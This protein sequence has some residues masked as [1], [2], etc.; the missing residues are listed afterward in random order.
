MPQ[1]PAY[2][3][4]EVK[5]AGIAL[6]SRGVDPDPKTLWH[7]L[8]SRGLP[9]T[10]WATWSARDQNAFDEI[11]PVDVMSP[12]SPELQ[13]ALRR[14]EIV[15]QQMIRLARIEAEEPLRRRIELLENSFR[16]EAKARRDLE[17]MIAALSDELEAERARSRR[18]AAS[19]L[20][21]LI[22]P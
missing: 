11:V 16:A 18:A 22:L 5:A 13:E 8:G 7:E 10:A 2:S 3:P 19:S 14:H 15:L 20:P 17:Q 21:R 6:L 1:K 12:E 9:Q 4:Q